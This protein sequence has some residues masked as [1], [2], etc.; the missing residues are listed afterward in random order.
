MALTA[1]QQAALRTE[2]SADPKARGYAV[3]KPDAPGMVLHLLN[4]QSD[5]MTKA[6]RSSTAQA[7]AAA[8]PYAAIVDASNNATNPCRASC[9]MLRDT[10]VSGVDIHLEL[11]DVQSMFSAWVSAGVI[12]QAQHDALYA[13]ADQPASRAEVLGIFG[14]TEDD[15][16]VAWQP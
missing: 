12:T 3:Y 10:L 16:R 14:V 7:W 5:S 6:I 1:D 4:E 11:P 13:K 2:L 9:L 15:V 8:G